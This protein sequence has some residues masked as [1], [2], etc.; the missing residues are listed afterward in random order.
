MALAEV[1]L[2]CGR[3]YLSVA[4]I[5]VAM[6]GD[7]CRDGNM[8]EEVLPAIPEAELEHAMIGDQ[9]AKDLPIDVVRFFRGD[10]W[11]EAMLE[12][13]AKVINEAADQQEP[14]HAE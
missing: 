2:S 5:A 14:P 7:K 11:N 12:H 13:A 4:G 10:C 8:P 1:R 3:L 9:R 6:E